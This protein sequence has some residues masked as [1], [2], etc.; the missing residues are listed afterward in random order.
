MALGLEYFR[1]PSEDSL[2]PMLMQ[3]IRQPRARAR[4]LTKRHPHVAPGAARP[5]IGARD[6]DGSRP[7]AHS[8]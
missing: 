5:A 2:L 4:V 3:P 8:G 7:P 1:E 6:D